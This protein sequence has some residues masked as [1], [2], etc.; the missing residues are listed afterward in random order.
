MQVVSRYGFKMSEWKTAEEILRRQ[1]YTCPY[2]GATL[3]LGVNA[4]LDHRLSKSKHPHLKNRWSNIQW[5]DW[6]INNIK[7][8]LSPSEFSKR[9]SSIGNK[10]PHG[11]STVGF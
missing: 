2:S 6:Y 10:K 9:L 5:V 1:N 8:T 7:Q 3:V 4:S 11:L